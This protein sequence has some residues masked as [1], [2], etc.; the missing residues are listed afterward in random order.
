MDLLVERGRQAIARSRAALARSDIA[1]S[2]A[3]QFCA[4]IRC[5]GPRARKEGSM[6]PDEEL[7]ELKSEQIRRKIEAAARARRLAVAFWSET[8]RDNALKL[9][10][11][12]EAQADEFGRLLATEDSKLPSSN[13]RMS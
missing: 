9:A 2:D 11:E 6:T 13:P 4:F 8:D 10:E 1:L 3:Y 7:R 5:L 12:L